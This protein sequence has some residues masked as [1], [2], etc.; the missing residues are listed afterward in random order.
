M[1]APARRPAVIV[2]AVLE[3]EVAACLR[4]CDPRPSVTILEQGLHNEPDRLREQLQ[5]TVDAVEDRCPQA[6]A[7]ALAYGLCSRG[8]VGLRSQR[9]PLVVPQV[10]D[11]ISLLLGSAE[12]YVAEMAAHPGTYWYSPGWNRHGDPPGPERMARVRAT[13]A[14]EYGEDNADYLMASL[15]HWVHDY[16]RA[17]YVHQDTGDTA[18]DAALTRRAA[19]HFGWSY[20]SLRGD[21]GLLYDL[22]T[23]R[24][25]ASRFCIAP[26]GCPLAMGDAPAILVPGAPE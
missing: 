26:A 3:D 9:L 25:D 6:D 4:D 1:A 17:V 22:V 23:G 5:A 19:E 14:A 13:Y 20:Q 2:C 11:C 10:H 7:V 15:E 12:R 16:D 24:W 18:A 8:L 21:P